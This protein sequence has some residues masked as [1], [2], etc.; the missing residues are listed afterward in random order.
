MF[1]LHVVVVVVVVARG[2]FLWDELVRFP[3]WL[4]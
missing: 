2:L 3:A 4:G 1:T